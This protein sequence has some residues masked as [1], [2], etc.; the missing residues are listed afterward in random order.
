MST[1]AT[2]WE[3]P[4]AVDPPSGAALRDAYRRVSEALGMRTAGWACLLLGVLSLAVG[5]VLGWLELVVAGI[6]AVVTVAIAL[7]FTI[8]KP[9]LAVGLRLSDRTVVVGDRAT[10]EVVVSNEAPRRHFGSRLDLPVGRQQASFSLPIMG[11]RQ[12]ERFT[13]R[14]PTSR[15]GL[16]VVGPANSVQ[17]DPFSLAGRGTRWTEELEVYVH[18]R[19]IRLPGRQTGFIHDLEGHASPHITSADMNFH[20]LRPY[21]PGDDRRHVH[22]KS[23][24]RAGEL[25]VRQFEESRMSRVLVALDTGRTSYIDEEEFELAV[26]VVASI[27]LQTLYGESPLVV[28]TSKERLTT[29]TPGGALDELS[30]VEQTARGGVADLAFTATQREPG[31]SIAILVTGSTASMT[32]VRHASARFDVDT[33]YIGIRVATGE[34]LRNRKVGSVTVNQIGALEDLPRAMRRSME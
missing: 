15:R 21:V 17:G 16:V 18:P 29:L 24:A 31:A 5:L 10:G 9:S 4:E 32:D 7:L 20:A 25:M 3:V 33:R 2:R 27:A 8:G 28:L 26:S 12:V 13:F 23:T 6:V 34:E 22:W 1:T 19:T 14:I 11:P 30:L